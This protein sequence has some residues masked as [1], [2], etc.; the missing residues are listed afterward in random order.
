MEDLLHLNE[1][2]TLYHHHLHLRNLFLLLLALLVPVAIQT[3]NH[4]GHVRTY[5]CL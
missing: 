3:C 4:F 1:S 5:N 2:R